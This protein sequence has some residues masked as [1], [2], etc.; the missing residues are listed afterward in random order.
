MAAKSKKAKVVRVSSDFDLARMLREPRPTK[1]TTGLFAWDEDQIRQAR[2]AQMDGAFAPARSLAKAVKTDGEILAALEN[3]QAPSRGIPVEV[4]PANGTARAA[5]VRDEAEP[6]F[7]RNGIAISAAT[8]GTLVEHLALHRVAIGYNVWTARDDGSRWDVVH[9]A[10]PLENVRWNRSLLTFEAFTEDGIVPIVHGDGTW[11]IY[12]KEELEP[13][14]NGALVALALI[15]A[16]A[17]FG[18]RDRAK[19]SVSHGNSK[20]IGTLPDGVALQVQNDDN[21]VSLS[22]AALAFLD[23]L[24]SLHEE[25]P[26]GIAPAG[27]KVEMLSD[28]S[29]AWQIWDSIINSNGKSAARVLVGSDGTVTDS[30]G[31]YIKST[32][33]FGVRNDIVEGDLESLTAGFDSGVIVPWTAINFGSSELA[34]SRAFLVPDADEAA[35]RETAA[36]NETA[37]WKSIEAAKANGCVVD[38]AYVDARAKVYG[39][40]PI[41]QLVVTATVS[42]STAEIFAYDIEQGIV[43]IDEARARKG[44]P[45]LPNGA[46]ARTV[47]D[48]KAAV[49]PPPAAPTPTPTSASRPRVV[50]A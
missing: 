36:A 50:G 19:S 4:K 16:D 42:T 12:T 32:M 44:L 22:P 1:R 37:F 3:R 45:P 40:E 24:R 34:P 49:A 47:P 2:A 6:L 26:A 31:N 39:I 46:G 43:T 28:T 7:K 38:Q 33:L 25:L 41:P 20:F 30:G 11:A 18:K 35:R 15:W 13:W 8:I 48:A 17:A 5:R 27:G 10:F 9:H 23:L 14:T 21:T 29:T